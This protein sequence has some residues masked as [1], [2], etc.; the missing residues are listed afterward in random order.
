VPNSVFED[1]A[2]SKVRRPAQHTYLTAYNLSL[3]E[4]GQLVGSA[5]TDSHISYCIQARAPAAARRGGREALRRALAR[6]WRVCS[7]LG[8]AAGNARRARALRAAGPSRARP[9]RPRRPP[10]S[11]ATAAT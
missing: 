4:L 8:G 9:P 1:H 6:P 3:K 7:C 10:R 11:A 5:F 2:G